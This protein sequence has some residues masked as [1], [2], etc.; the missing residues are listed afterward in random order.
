VGP[1]TWDPRPGLKTSDLSVLTLLLIAQLGSIDSTYASPALREFVARAVE[2]NR[3]APASLGAY[4]ARVESEVSLIARQVDGSEVVA[5]IEQMSSLVRWERPGRFEQHVIGHRQQSIGLQFTT[6]SFLRDSWLVPLLYGNRLALLFGRDSARRPITGRRQNVVRFAVHPLS[7]DRERYYLYR[8]GDTVVTM[9]VGERAIPVSRVL[10]EPR[11]DLAPNTVTFRGELDIDAARHEIVRMRGRFVNVAP[12]RTFVGKLQRAG[13]IEAIAFV[14]LENA[15]FDG[16]FWLPSYQR[17]ESHAAFPLLGEGRSVFRIVSRFRQLTPATRDPPVAQLTS[18][19][20]TVG[21]SDTLLVLTRPLTLASSDS[22]SRF[23]EWNTNIGRETARVHADDFAD[24]G[25]DRW[26]RTGR[27]IIEL[28]TER[29]AGLYHFNRIEG[30]FTGYGAEARLRDAVPGLTARAWGGWAWNEETARGGARVDWKRARSELSLRAGRSL[31]LTNDFRLPYDSGSTIAALVGIDLYDYV[32]RRSAVAGVTW[33]SRGRRG[34]RLRLEGGLASDAAVEP[35]VSRGIVRSTE[36]FRANRGVDEGHYRLTRME[37]EANPD[38]TAEFIR[39][40]TSARLTYERGDGDLD[41]ERTELRVMSRTNRGPFTLAARVDAG[42]LAGK[43]PPP[44]QL[45]EVGST[46]NLPGFA[47]KEFAGNRAVVARALA[48]YSFPIWRAPIRL[49]RRFMLPGPAPGVSAGVQSAWTEL[50]GDGARAAV[51]R[52]RDA[53]TAG[54][55]GAGAF[56]SVRVSRLV[57]RPTDGVKTS[58]D[59]RLRF[60]G[61]AVGGGF[62]RPVERGARWRFV[63]SFA[64]VL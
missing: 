40:G 31:D 12:A 50:H 10:V 58:V 18:D 37:L 1:G 6:L 38:V 5:S 9:R 43:R 28:R 54:V 60:F 27:P 41:Y 51:A 13:V 61:S 29:F 30:S 11:A 7:N 45:F 2:R 59:L 64:Q 24:V 26:R 33:K 49:G 22:L 44:Q 4:S 53:A 15:E 19:T 23:G 14:E 56:D 47:Y 16:R 62:A 39:P 63:L 8:G 17:F 3:L 34:V 21:T 20:T 32:D 57:S 35:H 55:L 52:L 42:V 48:I 46:Q 36:G 25:P